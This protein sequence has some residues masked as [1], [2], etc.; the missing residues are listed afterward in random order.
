MGRPAGDCCSLSGMS[1]SGGWLPPNAEAGIIFLF[2]FSGCENDV[3]RTVAFAAL[4]G[5]ATLREHTGAR[6]RFNYGVIGSIAHAGVGKL[7]ASGAVT[8]VGGGRTCA[9]WLS[10]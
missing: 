8:R 7:N 10:P 3:R 1:S 2:V 6:C 4:D 5:T 9:C